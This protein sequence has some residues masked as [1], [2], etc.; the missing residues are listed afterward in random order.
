MIRIKD[1]EGRILFIRPCTVFSIQEVQ[2][3]GVEGRVWVAVLSNGNAIGIT[4]RDAVRLV[5]LVNAEQG[6]EWKG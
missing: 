3:P 1:L 5:R 6:E 4:K 2:L